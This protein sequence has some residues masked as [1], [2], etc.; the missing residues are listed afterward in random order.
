VAVTAQPLRY[1]TSR[2]MRLAHS[3]CLLMVPWV[4]QSHGRMRQDEIVVRRLGR[5]P[6]RADA[7]RGGT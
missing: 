3:R 6:S 4:R 5:R 7:S 2:P 1:A